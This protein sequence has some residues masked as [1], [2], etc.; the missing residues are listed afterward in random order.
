LKGKTEDG[1]GAL[2]KIADFLNREGRLEE[3]TGFD[4]IPAKGDEAR[5]ELLDLV[6]RL[7]VPEEVATAL[8]RAV[9]AQQNIREVMP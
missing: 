7:E 2:Y 3:L 1:D 6:A 5:D 8:E 4:H 9:P